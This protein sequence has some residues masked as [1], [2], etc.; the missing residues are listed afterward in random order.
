[1]ASSARKQILVGVAAVALLLAAYLFFYSGRQGKLPDAFTIDGVCLKCE[2]ET[3]VTYRRRERAPFLCP[4]CGEQAVYSWIYCYEC[5]K[6]FVP[7]LTASDEGPP[8]MPVVPV[9]TAC[10]STRTGAYL[11]LDPFQ[12]PVANAPLPNMP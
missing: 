8:R 3:R 4:D 5:K 9:C 6:R 11:A 1:M 10:G 2:Q 12:E 7:K